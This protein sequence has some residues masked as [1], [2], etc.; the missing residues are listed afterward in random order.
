MVFDPFFYQL[1]LLGSYPGGGAT[2]SAADLSGQRLAAQ[3]GVH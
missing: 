3:H 1:V 2:H